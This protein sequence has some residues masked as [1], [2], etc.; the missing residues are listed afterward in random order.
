MKTCLLS[1]LVFGLILP[2][3][4]LAQTRGDINPK[5]WTVFNREVSFDKEVIHL[6]AGENDGI[7]WLN[8]SDLKNGTIELDIKGKD[9][10]GQSFVGIAFHGKDDQTFDAVYF[11]P[12]NFKS[13]ERKSHSVQYVSMPA[14]DWSV[15]RNRYPGK[16]EKVINPIPDPDGWFHAEI[17]VNHPNVS[18][19]V[20]GNKTESLKIEQLSDRAHGKIG[21]WVGNGSEGWFKNLTIIGK[22]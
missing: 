7:L 9:A 5:N 12:F 21:L 11:R 1:V 15:L 22:N 6:D 2:G 17:R 16:Y 20:N 18:V 19:Y 4:S 14:N 10:R 3:N 8:G 13:E